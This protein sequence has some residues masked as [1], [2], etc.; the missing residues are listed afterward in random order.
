MHLAMVVDA[1]TTTSSGPG[2]M[3]PDT[4]DRVAALAGALAE[5]GHSTCIYTPT[6][7]PAKPKRL[8]PDVTLRPIP[9]GEVNADR[10]PA[11]CGD[12]LADEWRR[13]PPELTHV[14]G[15][16]A[17]MAVA[18]ARRD[19]PMPVVQDTRFDMPPGAG[20]G[21][22][23]TRLELA[24]G[25]AAD[26]LVVSDT[27][28]ASTYAA[29]GVS[30]TAI[31]IVPYA[32]DLKVFNPEGPAPER[33]G[34]PR[35]GLLFD[36]ADVDEML[37][38]RSH[39]SDAEVM[40]LDTVGEPIEGVD[41]V[42][43]VCGDV[44]PQRLAERLRS[45]DLLVVGAA[46][47]SAGAV[48]EEAMACGV[49]L[50]VAGDA[51]TDEAVLDGVTGTVVQPGRPRQLL[52]AVRQLLRDDVR[53]TAYGIAAA[54][55]AASCFTLLRVARDMENSYGTAVRVGRYSGRAVTGSYARRG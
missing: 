7:A 32:V 27:R 6:E 48:C 4:S 20:D 8:L 17:G 41:E 33:A 34:E 53:R 55:R 35:V 24:L 42:V 18:A 49:P 52:D 16:R 11:Q 9:L 54:D 40:V 43:S 14:F 22:A 26:R 47:A 23:W 25:R 12:R 10:E 5:R 3:L 50:V 21:T 15:P 2:L 30:R 36:P 51:D 29:Q 19:A 1:D 44:D 31:D 38:L 28:E 45:L 39:L 13:R 46:W 37:A